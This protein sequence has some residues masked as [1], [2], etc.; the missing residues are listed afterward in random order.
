MSLDVD[1]A[2]AAVGLL[3]QQMGF[4][5]EAAALGVLDVAHANIDRAVRRVSVARGYDPRAFTLLAFGGAGPL[6]ACQVAERL[7]IPRL[8]VPRYPGVLCAL[9]L[10]MADVVLDASRSVLHTVSEGSGRALQAEL[11]KMIEQARDAL[12]RDGMDAADMAFSGWVDARYRGQSYELTIPFAGAL[13]E[14]LLESFHRAYAAQYGHAMPE[15]AVEAVNLRLQATGRVDKPVLRSE[16][17]VTGDG[18]EA[19]LGSRRVVCDEGAQSLELYAR[20]RLCPGASFAGPALVVQMD[21]TVYVAPGWV[22]RVDGYRNLVI[23]RV[24]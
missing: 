16:P 18:G 2:R 22:A 12:H 24:A 15:R 20:E 6:H 21:S 3:A 23:E 14:R 4:D 5:V 13:T 9:G 19:R 1:A 7:E 11:D 10:L 8:L 17:C